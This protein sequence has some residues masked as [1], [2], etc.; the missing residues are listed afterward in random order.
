MSCNHRH[1]LRL[2]SLER[3]DVPS[4]PTSWTVRGS[5]G[6]GALYAPSFSWT[7]ANELTIASD[8]SNL[9]HSADSGAS[10]TT[11]SQTEIQGNHNARVSY[12]NDPNIRYCLDYS[13]IAGSDLVRPSKTIDAGATWTPLAADPTDGGAFA[14]FG[15]PLNVNHLLVSDYNTAYFSADGGATFAAKFNTTDNN[16]GL[17]IAGAFF[18]GNN[19]YVG[20]NKGLYVSSNGGTSFELSAVTGIPA[21]EALVSFAGAK[22]GS[23][24]RLFGVTLGSANVYAGITGAD[25]GGYR[26]VYELDVGQPSWVKRVSGIAAG[27]FP[28]FIATATNDINTVYIAGGSNNAAPVV[29]KS[30]NAGT[31][32]TSVFQTINNQNIA[33]G[34][35]G[36]GGDRGWSYG[37]YALGLAV[38]PQ[39][40]ARAVFTDLGG[41]HLTLNGGTAWQARYVQPADLNPAGANTPTGRA[42]HD[43]GL[44]NTTSWSLT[45]A[46]ATT[47][48]LGNSDVRGQ[49]STDGGLTWG[50]GYMGHTDNSMFR[51]FRDPVSGRLYAATSSIHDMYQSTY[52]QDSRID[53]GT[54]KVL[55]SADNGA[56]WQ[57]LHAFADAVVW[58]APDPANANRLYASVINSTS[59][60]IYVSSDINLGGSST[61][62]KLASPPRTEGHPFNV[63][64]LNDGTL[65]ASYSGRR[66]TAGAFTASSGVFVSTDGGTTWADRSNAGMLYWTW[67]VVIDPADA[68]QSTWFAG[69]FSGWGGAP[70][71]LGG[72]Y[73]TTNRGVTWTRIN[74]LDRV[75]S[76]TIDPTNNNNA[77]LTTETEGLWYTTNLH[78]ANPTFTQVT[79]YPF[80]Q[81]TRVF[82]NPN[83][84]N[85]IWITS[86]GGGLM[87]GR[88]M[89]PP[90]V[91]GMQ[92]NDGSAQRS[93]V[94]SITITFNQSVTLPSNP[95][96]AFQ[97][98]R[99]SDGAAVTLAGTV[100]SNAV[101]LTFTGGAVNGL[102]LADGRYT[103]TALA[104]QINGGNFDGNGD[105]TP[106]DDYQLIGD[107]ATNK[108][109]RLFGDTN[110][111]GAIGA[112]DFVFFRQSFN[113]VN[114]IFDF[115]GDGFVSTSDFNQ[116]RNR[117]NTSI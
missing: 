67:D 17:H 64:V 113:S 97:L 39:D 36:Q 8:M 28:F 14:L 10:W 18:D 91:V 73:E 13:N 87:E 3:R 55:Y 12:T 57:T 61:W 32:W 86:F 25:F 110:G 29:Y 95:A 89:L 116:F 11:V 20:T 62:I 30:T 38:A 9:F 15:D 19:I 105:G 45:W 117:F 102:S 41:A 94:T 106:G 58:V 52:L 1:L 80:R 103:L 99:N 56:T 108:L 100:S 31:S 114:D 111:D 76:L 79:S 112:N 104:A 40:S 16:T 71:G 101:T 107:P 2:E 63:V 23:A 78:A 75:A 44:D 21:T 59:G 54:G 48:I 46:S 88:T 83:D 77:Y 47:M 98:K 24:T 70:N 27:T 37:E 4:T 84:A 96:D 69:V 66:N 43:S 34:W 60:G 22:Q 49:R 93:R 65:V 51:S 82:F 109:F 81:P 6:G 53:P 90:T 50:Y 26:G 115:D 42:Y 33:T 85:D 5:G 72:L 74:S 35:Q 68:T 7:D 92:V